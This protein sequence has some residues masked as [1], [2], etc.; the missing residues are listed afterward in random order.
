[1]L[2]GKLLWIV[3]AGLTS[4]VTVE[5][6]VRQHT[7]EPDIL[8]NIRQSKA[9][10][11]TLKEPEPVPVANGIRMG[12]VSGLLTAVDSLIGFCYRFTAGN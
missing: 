2:L 12:N 9:N 6:T 8:T 4:L 10:A 1:M 11:R 7:G 3:S 5:N